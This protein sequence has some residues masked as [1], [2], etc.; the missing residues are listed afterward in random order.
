MKV[1]LI[2]TYE[3]GRQPVHVASPA[4]ALLDAGHAVRAIDISVEPWDP[5]D[6]DWA[7]AVAISTPMHTAMRLAHNVAE[8][9]KQ[10]RPELPVAA[11]GLYA[12]AALDLGD[13][14]PF[15]RAIVGEYETAL[16][17][18]LDD[19]STEPALSVH[20]DR[21]GFRLPIRTILPPLD[22]YARLAIGGHKL[23]VG[24]VEASHGCLHMCRHCP[25]PAV[26]GG[27]LRVVDVETV[28]ADIDQQVAAGARHITFGDP[29]FLNGPAH[30]LRIVRGMHAR[31]P[32]LTFDC[33]VKVEH[34]LRYRDLWEEFA[35]SG[36]LFVVSAFE[37]MN[38]RILE[39]LDKGHTGEEA[40]IAVHLLRDFGIDIRP[41]WLPFTPWTTRADI[42]S[43]FRFIGTHDLV[44]STDPVQ[45]GIR[46]LI[47]LGSLMLELRELE[48][49]IGRYEPDALSYPWSSEDPEVDLLAKTLVE[50]AEA[51]VSSGRPTVDTFLEQWVAVVEG[52]DFASPPN[53][54]PQGATEA[55]PK[56]TES[57][58][59]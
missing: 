2:S 37:T 59:C 40:A 39:L 23:L 58:F 12:G 49:H 3:L 20:L 34:I 29:D 25:I 44:E 5:A 38:D 13:R 15:D 18:W 14:A 22:R 41:S 53:A 45:M 7:D 46:L 19:R 27:R 8:S 9:I 24:A 6:A 54:I 31:H 36:C 26:Y 21:G 57:W 50:I 55:R 28:L 42:E 51:G 52:T 1:L 4:S 11:Y 47:P 16:V 33:T 10:R 17:D 32:D 30:S 56:L 43:M 35:A 48:P